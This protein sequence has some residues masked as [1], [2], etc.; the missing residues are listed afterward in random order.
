MPHF[1]YKWGLYSLSKLSTFASVKMNSKIPTR[2][3]INKVHVTK[4]YMVSSD[5][6]NSRSYTS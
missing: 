5:V 1:P 4:N 2:I 3:I 6:A